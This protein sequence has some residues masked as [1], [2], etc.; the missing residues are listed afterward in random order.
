MS[1]RITESVGAWGVHSSER[2]FDRMTLPRSGDIIRWPS[3]R[4]GRV[5]TTKQDCGRHLGRDHRSPSLADPSASSRPTT[6]GPRTRPGRPTSGIGETACPALDRP[7]TTAPPHLLLLR[8]PRGAA[9]TAQGWTMSATRRR[10]RPGLRPTSSGVPRHDL[11]PEAR[12]AGTRQRR[13]PSSSDGPTNGKEEQRRRCQMARSGKTT[14]EQAPEAAKENAP[15]A[16]PEKDP[17]SLSMATSRTTRF[18]GTR[19]RTTSRCATSGSRLRASAGRRRTTTWC[20]GR[21]PP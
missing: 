8:R 13:S 1:D 12:A 2:T 17:G 21:R 6:T 20:A 15:A 7:S 4:L 9:R 11:T 5:W 19:I 14:A 3:G 10:P 16:R 18:S